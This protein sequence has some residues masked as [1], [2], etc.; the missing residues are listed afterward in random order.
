M[1]NGSTTN[2]WPARWP[3]WKNSPTRRNWANGLRKQ[4][5]VSIAALWSLVKEL[6]QWVI[7][8]AD[9]A[10]WTYADRAEVFFD[11]TQIEVFGPSFEGARINYENNLALSWQTLWFGP[12]TV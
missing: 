7:Q 6:V 1:P 10:R 5:E 3:A 4:S 8:R 11:D 12:L 2:R 9:A